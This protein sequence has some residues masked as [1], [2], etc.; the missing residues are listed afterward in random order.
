MQTG[1]AA[2]VACILLRVFGFFKRGSSTRARTTSCSSS[3]ESTQFLGRTNRAL[4][5][6]RHCAP[7]T[8]SLVQHLGSKTEPEPS[9]GGRDPCKIAIDHLLSVFL[10]KQV[11]FGNSYLIFTGRRFIAN[12]RRSS[13]SGNS[14]P[15]FYGSEISRLQQRPRADLL[16]SK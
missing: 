2:G 15:N 14:Q 1:G 8:T 16:F 3:S 10:R 12:K 11:R 4:P 5:S 6:R 7:P 9:P 13:S